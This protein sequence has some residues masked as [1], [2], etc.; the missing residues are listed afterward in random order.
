MFGKVGWG[1]GS[2]RC[3]IASGR[4]CVLIWDGGFGKKGGLGEEEEWS[5]EK[6]QMMGRLTFLSE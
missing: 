3:C 1:R 4:W 2:G 5:G 6:C